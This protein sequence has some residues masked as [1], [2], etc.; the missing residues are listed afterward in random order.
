MNGACIQFRAFRF[1]SIRFNG[2]YNQ[3]TFGQEKE[4]KGEKNASKR[5]NTSN[6]INYTHDSI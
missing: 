5:S 6:V 4:E 3:I 2:L 1:I